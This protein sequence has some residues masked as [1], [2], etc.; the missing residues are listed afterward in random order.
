[1]ARTRAGAAPIVFSQRALGRVRREA[2]P[3]PSAAE[4]A[5]EGEGADRTLLDALDSLPAEDCNSWKAPIASQPPLPRSA[6]TTSPITKWGKWKRKNKFDYKIMIGIT[7]GSKTSKELKC[8][9]FN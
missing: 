2:V 9:F 6:F 1:M 7:Y 5:Q 8:L 3:W 4:V